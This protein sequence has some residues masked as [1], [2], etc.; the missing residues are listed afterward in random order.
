MK[1]TFDA[2]DNVGA[3]TAKILANRACELYSSM[4]RMSRIVGVS[5]ITDASTRACWSTDPAVFMIPKKLIKDVVADLLLRGAQEGEETD[6]LQRLLGFFGAV[7]LGAQSDAE[8]LVKL[9][10]H[11]VVQLA[12]AVIGLVLEAEEGLQANAEAGVGMEEAQITIHRIGADPAGVKFPVE[13]L[14]QNILQRTIGEID[15]KPVRIPGAWRAVAFNLACDVLENLNEKLLLGLDLN[16][17]RLEGLAAAAFGDSFYDE[18]DVADAPD[19]P[20]PDDEGR[21]A[22]EAVE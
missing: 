15:G 6:S 17:E 7:Y 5:G 4:K 21:A 19:E 8:V 10:V 12:T 2:P 9:R 20:R 18:D 11:G 1:L 22:L 14:H 3:H 16:R 13:G